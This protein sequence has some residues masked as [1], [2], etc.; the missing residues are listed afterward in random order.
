[1]FSTTPTMLASTAFAISVAFLVA[2]CG[3]SAPTAEPAATPAAQPM[4]E[5]DMLHNHDHDHDHANNT[6]PPPGTEVDEPV[7]PQEHEHADDTGHTHSA[8]SA[9]A[10][11]TESIALAATSTPLIQGTYYNTPYWPVWWGTGK[12]VDGVGCLVSGKWHQHVLISI[13][14]DGK[15]LG[16]PDGI[17][18]VH[19]G[20][21]H[22][23]EMHTH[24]V[25]GLI[26]MEADVPKTFK[27]GQWFSL[28]GK[29]LS[30]DGVAGLAGPVR[31]YIIEKGIIT[32]YD[33]SPY[34]IVMTP[35]RE[36]LIVT[37]TEMTVVPRYQW[38]LGI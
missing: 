5:A 6:P 38:P 23:Y 27:L 22:A 34:D 13:Y 7:P 28:W 2:G 15:R 31:F 32:R 29:A 11:A 4:S 33:G 14:K 12:A 21:Y 3:G 30:R 1:M 26:H 17:G 16:F 9:A 19:A 25:T 36:I 20:C 35:R 18:R 8:G 10:V 24:D 37:G